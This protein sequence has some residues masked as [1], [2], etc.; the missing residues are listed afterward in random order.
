MYDFVVGD[1]ETAVAKLSKAADGTTYGRMNFCGGKTLLAKLYLNA[2][3]IRAPYRDKVISAC[4]EDK[5]ASIHWKVII[6]TISM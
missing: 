3:V 4:D 5:L 2:G 6:L 1:L